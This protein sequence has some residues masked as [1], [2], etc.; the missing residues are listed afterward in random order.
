MR[1]RYRYASPMP[2]NP[3]TD[4]RRAGAKTLAAVKDDASLVDYPAYALLLSLA[5]SATL[6]TSYLLHLG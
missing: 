3:R 1:Q 2:L 4:H 6:A 5:F